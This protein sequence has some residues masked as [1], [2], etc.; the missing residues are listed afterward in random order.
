[1]Q[2]PLH[3]LSWLEINRFIMQLE[4]AKSSATDHKDFVQSLQT[5]IESLEAEMATAK[6]TIDK[7]RTTNEAAVS[8]TVATAAVEHEALLKAKADIDAI[9][10]ETEALRSAH[11]SAID[12]AEKKVKALEEKAAQAETLRTEVDELKREKEENANKL[13]ELEVEVLELTEAQEKAEDDLAESRKRIAALEEQ[14]AEDVAAQ[15]KAVENAKARDVEHA[16]A[17][18]NLQHAQDARLTIVNGEL[19]D[20]TS[21]HTALE[22][23]LA[24]AQAALDQTKSEAAATAEEHGRLLL[25]AEDTYVAKEAE[26]KADIERLT[27][28][29]EVSYVHHLGPTLLNSL[30]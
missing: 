19:S 17:L 1:M 2:H 23:E 18:E 13:S 26:L 30:S 16:T 15:E 24:K 28:E 27:K 21:R 25:T 10:I 22:E 11:A 7:L 9:G 4:S 8:D 29:L 3:G 5:Q 14:V 6:E 20:A 12:D